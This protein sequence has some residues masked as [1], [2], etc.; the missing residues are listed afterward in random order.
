MSKFTHDQYFVVRFAVSADGAVSDIVFATEELAKRFLYL[1][2]D[3]CFDWALIHTTESVMVTKES[4]GMVL[5]SR[6]GKTK[7]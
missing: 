7:I 2:K 3:H 6:A 1:V 4:L 5:Q